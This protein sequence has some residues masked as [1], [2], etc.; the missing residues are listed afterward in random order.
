MKHIFKTVSVSFEGK[1]LHGYSIHYNNILYLKNHLSWLYLA[2]C[3]IYFKTELLCLTYIYL[4]IPYSLS[5][6]STFEQQVKMHLHSATIKSTN[7]QYF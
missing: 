2:Q 5:T 4:V 3:C 6:L 1:A 7:L